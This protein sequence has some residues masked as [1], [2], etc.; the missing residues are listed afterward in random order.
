MKERTGIGTAWMKVSRAIPL[1]E[2]APLHVICH[3]CVEL[4][5]EQRLDDWVTRLIARSTALGHS[6]AFSKP[7][8]VS[9]FRGIKVEIFQT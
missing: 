6:Q 8:Q 4:L 9:V 7:H 5:F 2:E 1:N 3:S